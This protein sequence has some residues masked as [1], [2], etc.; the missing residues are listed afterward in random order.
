[1]GLERRGF[2]DWNNPVI[3]AVLISFL[4]PMIKY[5]GK[6]LKR[7]IKKVFKVIASNF[8]DRSNH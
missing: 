8:K 3:Q 5:L 2:M 6:Q 1:M 7:L 4:S